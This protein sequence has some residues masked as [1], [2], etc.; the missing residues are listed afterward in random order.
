[1]RGDT[2]RRR[3]EPLSR[4][5]PLVGHVM[6]SGERYHHPP[7]RAWQKLTGAQ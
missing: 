4:A 6:V 5:A 7:P 3:F 2:H 1:M